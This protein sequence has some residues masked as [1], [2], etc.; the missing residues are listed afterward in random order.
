LR[1]CPSIDYPYIIAFKRGTSRAIVSL[2][3][4][5]QRFPYNSFALSL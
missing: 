1:D 5:S 3:L 4:K 2:F